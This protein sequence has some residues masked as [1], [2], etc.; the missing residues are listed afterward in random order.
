MNLCLL[1]DATLKIFGFQFHLYPLHYARHPSPNCSF[2]IASTFGFA[3]VI[4][5]GCLGQHSTHAKC[6]NKKENVSMAF[7]QNCVVITVLCMSYQCNCNLH[8]VIQSRI[9]QNNKPLDFPLNECFT[10]KCLNHI[11][12]IY[13]NYRALTSNNVEFSKDNIG[14]SH[15]LHDTALLSIKLSGHTEF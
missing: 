9:F 5:C 8:H 15:C 2:F 11:L 7:L 1:S 4:N 13:K 3:S 6:S 14:Q 12:N 10:M